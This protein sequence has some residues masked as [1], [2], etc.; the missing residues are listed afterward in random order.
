MKLIA[1]ALIII[2]GVVGFVLSYGFA[3]RTVADA[4]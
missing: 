4:F 2:S 3:Y 1:L